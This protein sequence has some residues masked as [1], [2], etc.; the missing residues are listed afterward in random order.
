MLICEDRQFSPCNSS[1]ELRRNEKDLVEANFDSSLLG[2]EGSKLFGEPEQGGPAVRW[3]AL[4]RV[5]ILK[6]K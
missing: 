2:R 6:N 1:K 4:E 5:G 3:T